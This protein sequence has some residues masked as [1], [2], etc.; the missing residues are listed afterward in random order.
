[1]SKKDSTQRASTGL[2]STR[3][4]VI[5]VVSATIGLL[6]S[7]GVSATC[8]EEGRSLATALLIAV[9]AGATAC[10]TAAAAL[11]ALVRLN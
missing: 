5:I 11:H 8:I 10:L 2:V 1:M 3:A 7:L 6:T 9:P 4:A